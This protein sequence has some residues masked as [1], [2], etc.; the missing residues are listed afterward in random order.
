MSARWSADRSP[1]LTVRAALDEREYE[2]G[3]KV[4]DE[5]MA[6][7]KITP[8]KFHGEWNHSIHPKR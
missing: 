1:G 2:T 7:L 6:K 8:D 4:A 3:L 5:E